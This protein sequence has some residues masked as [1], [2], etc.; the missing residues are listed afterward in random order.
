MSR[1]GRARPVSRKL[2]W[3][4][5]IPASAARP[6]WLIARRSRHCLR[7]RPTRFAV[8]PRAC[9][10]VPWPASTA[11]TIPGHHPAANYLRGN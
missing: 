11:A 5:E 10:P 4:A 8:T 3:R 1:L 6:S 7:R 9:L 2:R